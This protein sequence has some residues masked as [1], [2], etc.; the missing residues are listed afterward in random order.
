MEK[1]AGGPQIASNIA[2]LMT[3]VRVP[4]HATYDMVHSRLRRL[5]DREL[6][7]RISHYPAKW[8]LTHAGREALNG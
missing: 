8:E 1:L 3:L 6:V 4:T 2:Y 5:E 7:R